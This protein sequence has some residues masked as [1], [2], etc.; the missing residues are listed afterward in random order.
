MKLELFL[1]FF[2]SFGCLFGY[3]S[4]GEGSVMSLTPPEIINGSVEIPRWLCFSIFWDVRT[5][6]NFQQCYDCRC[7]IAC[8]AF[9]T[10]NT[11]K[12]NICTLSHNLPVHVHSLGIALHIHQPD[13]TQGMLVCTEHLKTLTYYFPHEVND[14]GNL[15]KRLEFYLVGFVFCKG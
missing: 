15:V 11:G 6:I 1:H 7:F 10:F 12:T 14:T 3:C 5:V 9:G 8:L 13:M 2:F 4:Y